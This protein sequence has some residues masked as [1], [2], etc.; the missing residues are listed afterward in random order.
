MILTVQY[1]RLQLQVTGL[2]PFFQSIVPWGPWKC[3][4]CSLSRTC[5]PS[6]GDPAMRNSGSRKAIYRLGS[7]KSGKGQFRWRRLCVLLLAFH[8]VF[9]TFLFAPVAG[10]TD[11]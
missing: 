11:P 7:F 8:F 3:F 5:F 6:V 4:R 1:A 2:G 9:E 10:V